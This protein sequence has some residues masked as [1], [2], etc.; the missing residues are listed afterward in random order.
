MIRTCLQQ[1]KLVVHRIMDGKHAL[2]VQNI[3]SGPRYRIRPAFLVH[4][5][6]FRNRG[7]YPPLSTSRT[8]TNKGFCHTS[9]TPP[10]HLG[11]TRTG[12]S[13]RWGRMLNMGRLH[14][15]RGVTLRLRLGI[16]VPVTI[17]IPEFTLSLVFA[18][19]FLLVGRRSRGEW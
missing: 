1:A 19:E 16:L 8:P 15:H 11:Q 10:H 18:F 13:T 12:E 3:P 4:Q 14:K 17:A 9:R 6:T 2:P 7:S 5:S